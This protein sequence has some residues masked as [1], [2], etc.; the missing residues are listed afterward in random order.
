MPT[1]VEAWLAEQTAERSPW[2]HP[3]MSDH[4]PVGRDGE[5]RCHPLDLTRSWLSRWRMV[6]R[7][8]DDTTQPARSGRVR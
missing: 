8:T 5:A 6:V 3:P 2:Q 7:S 1:L 4:R